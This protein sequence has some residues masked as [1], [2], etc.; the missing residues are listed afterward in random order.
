MIKIKIFL[1]KNLQKTKIY[2]FPIEGI[3]SIKGCS[4][5]QFKERLDKI[6]QMSDEMYFSSL[7]KNYN[8]AIENNKGENV[9][10]NIKKDIIKNL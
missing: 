3:C 10:D 8:Y 6:F 4:Y 9:I 5:D 2:D 7:E 1:C